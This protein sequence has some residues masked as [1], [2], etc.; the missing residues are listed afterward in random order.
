M[1][2]VSRRPGVA[3]VHEVFFL[4]NITLI[5]LTKRSSFLVFLINIFLLILIYDISLIAKTHTRTKYCPWIVSVPEDRKFNPRALSWRTDSTSVYL[6]LSYQFAPLPHQ[7]NIQ[8]SPTSVLHSSLILFV[9]IDFVCH[10]V[11]TLTFLQLSAT[12]TDVSMSLVLVF[13]N[14]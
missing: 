13:G 11:P 7:V 14:A 2:V 8:T 4:P 10:L 3:H 5:R 1:C 6:L 9:H 12:L